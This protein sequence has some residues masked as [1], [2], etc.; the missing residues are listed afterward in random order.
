MKLYSYVVARDFGFAPNPF[1]GY[2]TL[3]TCKPSIRLRASVGDWV[4]GTGS[5][6]YG[7]VG[8]A[9]YAMQV[10]ETRTFDEY[11]NDPRFA[12]KKPELRGSWKRAYG[13]NI[14]HRSEDGSWQQED[15]HHSLA[16]G[17]TNKENLQ[18]DTGRCD[19]VLIS[20]RFW[21][22]GRNGPEIPNHLRE[23]EDMDICVSGR[24]RKCRFAHQLVNEFVQWVVAQ[25]T[26]GVL[27]EPAEFPLG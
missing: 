12:S 13:D 3:A 16:D 26:N 22:W 21:Y 10:A 15:S 25:G 27:G 20:E 17:S 4:L 6:S 23:N 7:L 18:R 2:C 9:V 14:Y 19:R 8:H 5:A 11:W 1:H 24:G